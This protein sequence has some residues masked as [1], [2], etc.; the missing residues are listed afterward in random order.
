[1]TKSTP[2]TFVLV[3]G[4]WHGGWVWQTLAEHLREQ[5]HRVYTPTLTGLG[6]RSHLLSESITLETFI[7]DI[8]NVFKWENIN[9]AVLLGH[10]FGSL[11]A[12]GVADRIPERIRQLI[13]LDGFLLENGQ[14]V[15]DTLPE[16]AVEKLKYIS[17]IQCNG[18]A[19]PSPR[20]VLGGYPDDEETTELIANLLTPHPIGTY[21]SKLELHHPLGNYLP[22]TYYK[23]TN[24]PYDPVAH[25]HVLA[26]KQQGWSIVKLPTPHAAPFTHPHL[27]ADLLL[28]F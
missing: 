23:C 7:T 13:F 21:T 11:V 1:M 6:E 15:F 5:G 27:L 17:Q 24:P 19:L 3:H 28:S 8:L 10:S 12:S 4:A 2:T 14:S 20:P 18:L 9:D 22:V 16:K 25:S 26:K